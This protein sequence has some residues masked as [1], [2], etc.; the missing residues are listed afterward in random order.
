MWQISYPPANGATLGSDLVKNDLRRCPNFFFSLVY[1]ASPEIIGV[2]VRYRR[3]DRQIFDT[4]Y[5]WVCF[6]LQSK[7]STSLLASLAGGQ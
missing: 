1:S 5:G 4:V 2:K 6:F 3:T 7:F